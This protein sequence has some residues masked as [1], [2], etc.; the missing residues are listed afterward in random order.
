M[1]TSNVI[2]R[3]ILTLS[4]SFRSSL[5]T[6]DTST[7]SIS[8]NLSLPPV[9]GLSNHSISPLLLLPQ[10]QATAVNADP[11]DD[12]PVARRLRS[13]RR[14]SSS[15]PS[16]QRLPDSP[17]SQKA[18]HQLRD[19]LTGAFIR[20]TSSDDPSYS[21]STL[22]KRNGSFSLNSRKSSRPPP[23]PFEIPFLYDR[24]ESSDEEG[25]SRRKKRKRTT[26]EAEHEG[27]E[28]WKEWK[29]NMGFIQVARYDV[30]DAM[31]GRGAL[32]RWGWWKE[33]GTEQTNEEHATEEGRKLTQRDASV[34][35]QIGGNQTTNTERER[36]SNGVAETIGVVSLQPSDSSTTSSTQTAL[37]LAKAALPRLRAHITQ[38]PSILDASMPPPVSSKSKSKRKRKTEGSSKRRPSIDY[39]TRTSTRIALKQATAPIEEEEE[40]NSARVSE[41]KDQALPVSKSSSSLIFILPKPVPTSANASSSLLLSTTVSASTTAPTPIPSVLKSD[42]TPSLALCASPLPFPLCL[43]AHDSSPASDSKLKGDESFNS[44]SRT[45]DEEEVLMALLDLS[46]STCCQELMG[47]V[48]SLK[49]AGEGGKITSEEVEDEIRTNRMEEMN[50]IEETEGSKRSEDASELARTRPVATP[51]SSL[52]TPSPD[53]SQSIELPEFDSRSL[54]LDP[55]LPPVSSAQGCCFDLVD[56]KVTLKSSLPPSSTIEYVP[57]S[58]VSPE[59]SFSPLLPASTST[60]A[61]SCKPRS[62]SMNRSDRPQSTSAIS[63][64][65]NKP[66]LF[67]SKIERSDSVLAT[68]RPSFPPEG[69]ERSVKTREN[70]S[71]RMAE[72]IE[73]KRKEVAE[74]ANE[75]KERLWG[76]C[77]DGDGGKLD[78]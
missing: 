24:S 27:D 32:R 56:S 62:Q 5:I 45:E 41:T 77:E 38:T 37:T 34:E 59:T 17:A 15:A 58:P 54:A 73:A 57:P 39:G 47:E 43:P 78:L 61:L 21:P 68:L 55:S 7:R 40:E 65:A 23:R 4:S 26:E 31:G 9:S 74:E 14:N 63:A 64:L 42:K 6:G 20:S 30:I 48:N 25:R 72:T 75:L 13:N 67:T 49:I 28:E 1:E 16:R 66:Q 36:E 33:K 11:T 12:L 44:N 8:H 52:P 19:P 71:G 3:R 46:G 70:G 18:R 60:S 29:K 35:A 2:Y 10:P 76:D 50:E 53:G 22:T 51:Q 69:E